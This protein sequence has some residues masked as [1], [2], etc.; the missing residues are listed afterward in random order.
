MQKKSVPIREQNGQINILRHNACKLQANPMICFPNNTGATHYPFLFSFL[1]LSF[2]VNLLPGISC[3]SSSNS[4]CKD[5]W[6]LAVMPVSTWTGFGNISW[7][8]LHKNDSCPLFGSSNKITTH[9][10][11]M[12]TGRAWFPKWSGSWKY[13]GMERVNATW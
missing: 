3:L 11:R 4:L 13:E 8:K 10:F 5:I 12:K 2:P 6:L 1:L 9:K 7:W